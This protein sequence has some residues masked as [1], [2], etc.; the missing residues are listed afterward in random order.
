MNSDLTQAI[1][2]DIFCTISAGVNLEKTLIAHVRLRLNEIIFHDKTTRHCVLH[3]FLDK[4]Q[5]R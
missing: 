2:V 4:E 3:M 5:S 1:A